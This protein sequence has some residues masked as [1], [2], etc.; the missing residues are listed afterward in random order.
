MGV[1]NEDYDPDDDIDIYL[2]NVSE[3]LTAL[4][5]IEEISTVGCT[6]NIRDEANRPS[7]K[8]ETESEMIDRLKTEAGR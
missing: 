5:D 7:L 1:D 8:F 6:K 4:S 2:S 3:V